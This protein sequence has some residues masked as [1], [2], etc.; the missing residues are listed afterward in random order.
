MFNS[1]VYKCKLLVVDPATRVN[2]DESFK[3]NIMNAKTKVLFEVM[4]QNTWNPNYF[5]EIITNKKIP[6]YRLSHYVTPSA[7]DGT[8][9]V[10]LPSKPYFIKYNVD[11]GVEDTYIKDDLEEA[12]PDEIEEYIESHSDKM[13]YASILESFFRRAEKDYKNAESMGVVSDRKQVKR[14]LKSLKK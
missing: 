6:V 10:D 8:T 13:E 11:L 2:V 1:P 5:R 9:H 7:L 3:D 14:L 4:V 12:S